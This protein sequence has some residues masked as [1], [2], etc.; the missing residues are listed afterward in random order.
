MEFADM[1]KYDL[2]AAL[3]MDEEQLSGEREG[4]ARE[5]HSLLMKLVSFMLLLLEDPLNCVVSR[6]KTSH[7]MENPS[8]AK[9]FILP[10]HYVLKRQ[11]DPIKSLFETG[12][13]W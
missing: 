5:I 13:T 1:H 2:R 3:N 4:I 7:Q 9:F 6:W 10:V 12:A 8:E 11:I